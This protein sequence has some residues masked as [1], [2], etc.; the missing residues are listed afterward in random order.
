M[1]RARPSNDV[2]ARAARIGSLLQP[3]AGAFVSASG[4]AQR[5]PAI[6]AYMVRDVL[7]RTTSPAQPSG[8][9]QAAAEQ[10]KIMLAAS[11]RH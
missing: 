5:P 2:L 6:D 4:S 7:M 1:L 3:L 11:V 9:K 10:C 8:Q